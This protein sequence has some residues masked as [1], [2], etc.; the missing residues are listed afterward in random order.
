MRLLQAAPDLHTWILTRCLVLDDEEESR[1]WEHEYLAN[2]EVK[3]NCTS[4]N[5]RQ[6]SGN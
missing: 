4:A 5:D 1:T 6:I 3:R 2:K